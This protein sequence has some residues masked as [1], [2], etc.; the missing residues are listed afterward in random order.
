MRRPPERPTVGRPPGMA[1]IER[2]AP[3]VLRSGVPYGPSELKSRSGASYGTPATR[4]I[5][6]ARRRCWR[7]H[8]PT[9]PAPSR[10]PLFDASSAAG[11]RRGR[12]QGGRS[13]PVRG[14]VYAADWS[15]WGRAQLTGLSCGTRT[16]TSTSPRHAPASGSPGPA[17][18]PDVAQALALG[19]RRLS[20]SAGGCVDASSCRTLTGSM[21]PERSV[22][23]L[24]PSV[25]RGMETRRIVVYCF[26]TR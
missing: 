3:A 6:P 1:D 14:V 2:R 23:P 18:Q 13:A 10:E 25:A 7:V 15:S 24:S 11:R 20:I 4:G 22:E 9:V 26:A 17:Q 12:D 8:P 21:W 16:S 5:G 19:A